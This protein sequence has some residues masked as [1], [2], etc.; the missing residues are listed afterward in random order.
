MKNIIIELRRMCWL[1][2]E[3]SKLRA[4]AASEK[5]REREREDGGIYYKKKGAGESQVQRRKQHVPS[6]FIYEYI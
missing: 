6:T 1:H 3:K 2:R 5:E 4:H